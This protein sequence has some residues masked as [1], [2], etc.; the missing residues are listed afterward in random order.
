MK[1][2]TILAVLLFAILMNFGCATLQSKTKNMRN[3]F[4][5]KPVPARITSFW[6]PGVGHEKGEAYRGFTG[7]VYFY[8]N[9][10]VLPL[11]IN[12]TVIIYAFD[13]SGR[14]PDDAEADVSYV[15]TAKDLEAKHYDKTDIGHSYCFWLPWDKANGMQE[16]ISL[17]VKYFPDN[18]SAIFSSMATVVLPGK[19]N[20][21]ITQR[22]DPNGEFAQVSYQDERNGNSRLPRDI[23][24]NLAREERDREM[25]ANLAER[26]ITDKNRNRTQF[27]VKT[28]DRN[29]SE[30]LA[31][32]PASTFE[33]QI[34]QRNELAQDIEM[35]RY[36]QEVPANNRAI[37]GDY[38]R[39]IETKETGSGYEFDS[40]QDLIAKNLQGQNTNASSPRTA[41]MN[42]EPFN[43]E[44]NIPET[45]IRSERLPESNPATPNRYNQNVPGNDAGTG[46]A[47]YRETIVPVNSGDYSISDPRAINAPLR[48]PLN[49]YEPTIPPVPNGPFAP[50]EPGHDVNRQPRSGLPL[51]R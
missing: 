11:K 24:Y 26:H 2:Y 19:E 4:A 22:H 36:A 3:P 38:V 31:A 50:V 5:P 30:F 20:P 16:E 34:P 15:F 25:F 49:H 29:S 41:L 39:P 17:L 47:N 44:E 10:S 45:M 18:G 35:V 51:Y 12:G 13:E 14:K 37:T 28:I 48:Q 27:T 43:R 42:P 6:T 9:Q 21:L 46:F 1:R 8:D 33:R 40:I 32:I 23:S 7:R